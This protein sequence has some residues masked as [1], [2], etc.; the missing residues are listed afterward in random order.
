M[1]VK[2]EVLPLDISPNELR[3]DLNLLGALGFQL[4][5]RPLRLNWQQALEG[6]SARAPSYHNES[7]EVLVLVCPEEAE[8]P[9][10]EDDD[11]SG[12]LDSEEEP[13]EG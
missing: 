10:F 6:D 8:D 2:Y 12:E 13:S 5:P 11:G 7:C 3:R 9:Y 1:T 4:I